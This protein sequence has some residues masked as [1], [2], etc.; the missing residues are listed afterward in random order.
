MKKFGREEAEAAGGQ[1]P[2]PP[3]QQSALVDVLRSCNE[4]N[5]R[6]VVLNACSTRQQA[7]AL[8]ECRLRREYEPDHH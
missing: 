6:L 3:L 2:T 8:T 5:L 4:G 1:G 7:E